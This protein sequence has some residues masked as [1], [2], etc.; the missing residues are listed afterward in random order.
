MDPDSVLILKVV[1]A[2]LIFVVGAAGAY[3]A[4]K[5][6]GSGRS[7]L[8]SIGN[9]VAGGV[10]I[11]AG[12]IHTLADSASLYGTLFPNL[13]F[14]AWAA[15]AGLTVLLLLWID[16]RLSSSSTSDNAS[17]FA[18]FIVLSLHSLIAGM[19]LGVETHPAQSVAILVAILAHK[20]SA[21]FALGLRT[22]NEKYW[23][24]LFGFA[25]MTPIGVLLGAAMTATLK[26]TSSLYFEAVFDSVAAGTFLYVALCEI[27]PGEMSQ[28]KNSAG[29]AASA[30]AGLLLMALLA[31]YT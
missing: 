22:A 12:L 29:L 11:G 8:L 4:I 7:N 9:C 10:F 28:A 25:L 13:D 19:A 3:S 1:S 16:R 27:L 6:Q 14:P 17:S 24:Q 2:V 23:L 18:L 26:G 31:L 21:A 5:I 20:G 15:T 30:L